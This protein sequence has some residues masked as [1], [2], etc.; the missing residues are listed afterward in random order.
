MDERWRQWPI[1]DPGIREKPLADGSLTLFHPG[2]RE[3]LTL[4]PLAAFLWGSSG[5]AATVAALVGEVR[6]LF[7]G[8]AGVE[9]DVRALLEALA[10]K[11]F[12]TLAD[13][14][15]SAERPATGAR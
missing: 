10:A 14:P 15:P 12:L 7:P 1:R 2:T 13:A 9:E 8:Q 3:F 4:N 5:G 11:G 6:A